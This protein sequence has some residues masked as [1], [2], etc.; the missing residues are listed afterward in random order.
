M[1]ED[2]PTQ[3]DQQAVPEPKADDFTFKMPTKLLGSTLGKSDTQNSNMLSYKFTKEN[4]FGQ[5]TG[6]EFVDR[7]GD[8][9]LQQL[10]SL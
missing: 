4:I 2:K 6:P 1:R 5:H 10:K 9:Y 3:R 8:D 7:D